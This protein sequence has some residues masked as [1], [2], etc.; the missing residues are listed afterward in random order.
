MKKETIILISLYLLNLSL[1]TWPLLAQE[2]YLKMVL[3]AALTSRVNENTKLVVKHHI[4]PVA[5][6][7]EECYAHEA[8]V[9]VFVIHGRQQPSDIC[10]LPHVVIDIKT[11]ASI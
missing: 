11:V 1:A 3:V 6:P 9:A 2:T 7:G 10:R 5:S 4:R 8:L